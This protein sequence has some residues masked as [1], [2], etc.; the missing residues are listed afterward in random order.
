MEIYLI[1]HTK[2]DISPGIC[3]GKTDLLPV[4]TFKSESALIKEEISDITFDF[5]YSSPLKRC[6]MLADE[7]FESYIISD[8]LTEMNFGR[9]EGLSW[10]AIFQDPEGKKWFDNYMTYSCPEGESFQDLCDRVKCFTEQ[11]KNKQF[12]KIALVTHAGVIRAFRIIFEKR[13]PESLFSEKLN[14]G[15]I[16]IVQLDL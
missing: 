14:Y 7:L 15:D 10:D 13:N 8:L 5:V 9:W 2:P 16:V 12:S 1:R 4:A 3:Y 11:L 6:S